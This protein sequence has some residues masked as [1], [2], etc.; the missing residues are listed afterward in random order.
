V[1]H[2]IKEGNRLYVII[3]RGV[4]SATGNLITD[5]ERLADPIFVGEPSSGFGNQDGDESRATLP[6]S[7][8]NAWLT[9]VRWQYSHPWDKRTSIVP[10]VPVQLTAKAYFEGRDPALETIMALIKRG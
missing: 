6:Y 8:V 9:S 2:S 5:L 1:A 4:Y 10:Q 7:G 3:G